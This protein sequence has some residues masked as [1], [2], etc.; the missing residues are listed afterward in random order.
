MWLS[1]GGTIA[2]ARSVVAVSVFDNETG[3]SRYDRLVSNLSDTVVVR[4]TEMA[5]S[6][7]SVIGNAEALRQ[8]RNIRNLKALAAA[9]RADYVLLGQLQRTDTGLRFVTH[10]IRLPEEAHVRAR[11]LSTSNGDTSALEVA[12]VTEFEQ[13]VRQHVLGGQTRRI[14]SEPEVAFQVVDG[15]SFQA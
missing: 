5:P 11:S 8:P 12:V 1:S 15:A 10:V 9:V 2:D 6:R 3:D 14:L 4:L 13:A 7:I